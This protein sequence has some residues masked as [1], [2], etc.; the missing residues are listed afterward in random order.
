MP[1]VGASGL[2]SPDDL[3]RPAALLTSL[4]LMPTPKRPEGNTEGIMDERERKQGAR[5]LRRATAGD[6]ENR[7]MLALAS[8]FSD[9]DKRQAGQ[10]G[11]S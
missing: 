9:R 7:L 2:N 8:A 1:E 10:G 5:E 3:A 4:N 6:V 11:A